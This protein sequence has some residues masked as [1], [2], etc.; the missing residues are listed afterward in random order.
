MITLTIPGEPKGKLRP[1][2]SPV[3][4]YTPK[5]TVEYETYVRELFV[6][7]YPDFVPLEGSLR[8]YLIAYQMIPKSFS[9]KKLALIEEGLLKPSKNP[10]FDNILKTVVDA[11]EKVAFRNDNQ[12]CSALIEKEYS[13]KPRVELLIDEIYR[14]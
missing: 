13:K 1:K 8:L 5:K 9:K 6:I 11:L 7:K 2:W 3:G 12:F 14:S 4:T 10:D